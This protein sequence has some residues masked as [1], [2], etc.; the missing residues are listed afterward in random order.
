MSR[1][2]HVTQKAAAYR[3]KRDGPSHNT[4]PINPSPDRLQFTNE[5]FVDALTD[6]IIADDQVR[7]S[8][9]ILLMGANYGYF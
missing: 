9:N 4:N 2:E 6:F 7:Q 5:A 3:A 1:N 8:L